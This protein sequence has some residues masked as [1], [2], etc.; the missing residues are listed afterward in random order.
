MKR[1]FKMASGAYFVFLWDSTS[2]ASPSVRGQEELIYGKQKTHPNTDGLSPFLITP[3]AWCLSGH[4][5][6]DMMSIYSPRDVLRDKG[7]IAHIYDS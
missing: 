6:C 1:A 5:A 4:L 2:R 7:L 3:G